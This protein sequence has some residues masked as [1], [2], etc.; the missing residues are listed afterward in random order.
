MSTAPPFRHPAAFCALAGGLLAC[1]RSA[2]TAPSAPAFEDLRVRVVR[3]VPHDRQAFTQGLL[4]FDGRLYESTGMLG[5]STVRRVDPDSGRVEA[6]AALPPDVFGEGLAR[7]GG[8]LI[9]LTW[10]NGRAIY[11]NLASLT[12]EREVSYEG[13]GWGLCFDGKRLVMS[14]G[15][16]RLAFRDPETFA[17]QGEVAV[18]R[19]GV[20]VSSLNELECD[21]GVI[22]ANVWQD[23]HIARIDPAT[24]A[25]TGWI[26]AAGLL[27]PEDARGADVLNGIAAVP[28]TRH[29]LLT[30]K[31]WPRAFEVELVPRR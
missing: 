10:K 17:K 9:Q 6:R 2:A 12:K 8:R 5:Q 7:V 15:S 30:G 1:A 26:D 11:W 21:S 29:L 16:D 13:E 25:V 4:F 24:G 22:Y 19:G 31:F 18:R 3:T 20:P 28:G 23:N 14:D 27:A